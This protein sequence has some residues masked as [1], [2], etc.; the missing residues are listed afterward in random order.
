MNQ[1]ISMQ[2]GMCHAGVGEYIIPIDYQGNL[3]GVINVG[4]FQVE[5]DLA[6][7][8]VREVCKRSRKILPL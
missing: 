5:A 3:L 2:K 7:Y 6:T 8:L 4:V 1:R